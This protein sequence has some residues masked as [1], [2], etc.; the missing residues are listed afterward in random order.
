MVQQQMATEIKQMQKEHPEMASM[1]DDQQKAASKIMGDYMAKVMNLYTS[2]E[3]MDDMAG[4]YLKHLSG[5]DVD[6]MIV[7]YGSPAGQHM[8]DM[9]PVIMQEFV[10]TITNRIQERIKPAMDE[11]TKEMEAVMKSKPAATAP[12]APK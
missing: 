8:L 3:M 9:V 11:M 7:F 2:D 5:A 1:T 10:P 6:A 12:V 4:I